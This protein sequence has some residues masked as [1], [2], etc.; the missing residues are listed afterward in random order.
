M[1]AYKVNHFIVIG[2]SI[3]VSVT[4]L[5]SSP[6]NYVSAISYSELNIISIVK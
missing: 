2:G 4:L 5:A 6:E 3:S 1:D